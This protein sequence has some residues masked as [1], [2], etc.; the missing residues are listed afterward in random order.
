VPADPHLPVRLLGLNDLHGHLTGRGLSYTDPYTGRTGPTGGIAAL[1]AQ[2]RAR[3]RHDPG[4]TLIVHSGDMIGGSPPEAALLRDEPVIRILNRLGLVAGTPGNHEFGNG[5]PELLRLVH[6]GDGFEGQNFPMISSNI[7]RRDTRQPLF[8]PFLITE[9]DRIPIAFLGATVTSTPLLTTPATTDD[10]IFL[11]E[12]R[13]VRHHLP[14]LHNLGVHAIVLLLHE[15]GKQ[16]R[17]PHGDVSARVS[18]IAAALP[19]VGV[20]MAAHTHHSINTHVDGR[21]VIQAAPF[22][23]AFTDVHLTLDRSTGRIAAAHGDLVPVWADS[24]TEPD[25]HRVV[26]QALTATAAR[27]ARTVNTSARRLTAGRDDGATPAGESA[28]GNLI[29]DALRTATGADLAFVN[30]G[31]IRTCIPAGPVTWGDLFAVLPCGNNLITCSLTGAQIWDLLGQQSRHRFRRNLEVS[32]LHYTYRRHPDHGGDITG[33]WAGPPHQRQRTIR[34]DAGERYTVAV[35]TFL[36]AGGDGYRSLRDAQRVRHHGTELDALISHL[37][38]LPTPFN[39]S[40][41][42]RIT[43]T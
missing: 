22:G 9:V 31:G 37:S 7:V 14:H 1:A 6:G 11:D 23:R 30:P 39:A 5:L 26:E 38:T 21:L 13:A 32:G 43:R 20:V 41:E 33:M 35:N 3:R 19:E 27:T 28:L 42:N 24:P 40:I 4:R 8:P 17:F 34:R 29:A 16:S 2:L 15:G 36:A 10:L 18:D 25:I 12:A